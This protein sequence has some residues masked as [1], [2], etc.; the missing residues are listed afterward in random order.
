MLVS[1]LWF[2]IR[3][4]PCSN[5]L[6]S[7]VDV[8]I[9]ENQY[10]PNKELNPPMFLFLGFYTRYPDQK[11]RTNQNESI[12]ERPGKLKAWAGPPVLE[13]QVYLGFQGLGARPRSGFRMSGVR[14]SRSLSH[15]ES[16]S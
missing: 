16:K 11:I 13:L 4:R 2:G 8:L 15:L 9:R 14:E 12:L 6:A 3:G 1:R 7:A 10:K 5:F